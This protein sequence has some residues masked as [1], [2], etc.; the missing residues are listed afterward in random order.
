MIIPKDWKRNNR[1]LYDLLT[2]VIEHSV[3]HYVVRSW[4]DKAAYEAENWA[5][6]MHLR[7]S[8]NIV[9][10][11]PVPDFLRQTMALSNQYHQCRW[12]QVLDADVLV[13]F[14]QD[15]MCKGVKKVVKVEIPNMVNDGFPICQECGAK[16]TYSHTEVL[17]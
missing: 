17:S 14:K 4:S 7:A 13:Q 3:S 11:P 15:C 10:V 16:Y 8:D 1:I 2:L 12:H 9:S 6:R 5:V